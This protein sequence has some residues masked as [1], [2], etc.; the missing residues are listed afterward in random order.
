MDNLDNNIDTIWCEP[1]NEHYF[2]YSLNSFDKPHLIERDDLIIFLTQNSKVS[3]IKVDYLVRRFKS[4]LV[5]VQAQE[6]LE[7]TIDEAVKNE[8]Y[9]KALS[10]ENAI[11]FQ[12]AQEEKTSSLEKTINKRKKLF[13]PFMAFQLGKKERK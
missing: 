5:D 2:T 9:R 7:I 8:E 6:I 1:F 3:M 12:E 10:F 13:D 4:F 11:L